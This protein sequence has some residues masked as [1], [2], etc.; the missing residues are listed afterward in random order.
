MVAAGDA[1]DEHCFSKDID[2]FDLALVLEREPDARPTLQ[3]LM[4][5]KRAVLEQRFVHGDAEL[6]EDF[7]LLDVL[8]YTP[9]YDYCMEIIL[10]NMQG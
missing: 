1:Q 2:I 6:R 5:Q 10:V 7:A 9:T 8:E 4:K 3:K